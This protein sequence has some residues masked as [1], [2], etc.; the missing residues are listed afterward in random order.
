[1]ATI[2]ISDLRPAGAGLFTDSESFLGSMR[3]LSE[4]E[5]SIRGGGGSCKSYKSYHSYSGSGCCCY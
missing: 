1:M 2:A 3:D 4:D 5:L